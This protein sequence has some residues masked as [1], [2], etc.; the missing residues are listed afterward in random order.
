M[1]LITWAEDN[2]TLLLILLLS[3]TAVYMFARAKRRDD[4]DVLD[5]SKVGNITVE[6]LSKY[7][8]VDPF[9]P[10]YLAVRSVIFDV[11]DGKDFYGPSAP[12]AQYWGL[13]NPSSTMLYRNKSS[14]SCT[15]LLATT[16]CP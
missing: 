13:R 10:L 6:E 4:E 1:G 2:Q 3:L 16:D 12:A 8:G 11:T 14:A 5:T 7:C 15:P 9:R